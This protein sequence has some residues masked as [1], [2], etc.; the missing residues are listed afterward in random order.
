MYGRGVSRPDP[1]QL[2]PYLTED[3]STN[4]ATYRKGNP[5][6]RPEHA[7]NYDLLYERY[8]NP[9]GILQAG[10]FYKQLSNTLISTRIPRPADLMTRVT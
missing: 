6:L 9:A 10:F 4:P 2:V 7:N 1:Y 3:D 8:L 5:K